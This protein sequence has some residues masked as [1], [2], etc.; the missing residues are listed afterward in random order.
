MQRSQSRRRCVI[1]WVGAGVAILAVLV[2]LPWLYDCI[3]R[4]SHTVIHDLVVDGKHVNLAMERSSTRMLGDPRALSIGGG[5][6]RYRNKVSI[7]GK[8]FADVTT[9]ADPWALWSIEGKWYLVC[10][11]FSPGEWYIMR[12]DGGHHA[13]RL[14]RASLPAAT[15][16]WNLVE[17]DQVE[18]CQIEFDRKHTPG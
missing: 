10:F 14:P 6:W 18:G 1:K 9:A 8:P 2:F 16:P 15:R 13:T 3:T 11:E 4:E 17:P 7:D 12:L 5:N